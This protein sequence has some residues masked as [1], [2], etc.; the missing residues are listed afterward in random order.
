MRVLVTNDDGIAS[1]GLWVLA[2]T[3]AAEGH[4][5]VVVA[6]QGECSGVGAAI[7]H[8]F[9]GREI[10]VHRAEP[11]C[12]FSGE[13]WALDATPALCT[14]VAQCTRAF[15]P[16]FAACAAGVNP[17]FNTGALV[18]HSGTVGAA[19]TAANTGIP[20]VAVSIGA[21]QS[22]PTRAA[23]DQVAEVHHEGSCH[24]GTAARLAAAALA[25]HAARTEAERPGVVVN[26]NVPNAAPA[27]VLGVREAPLA[28]FPPSFGY[29]PPLEPGATSIRLGLGP[30]GRSL[31]RAR[32]G[33]ATAERV[34]VAAATDTALVAQG[35]ATAT[36]LRPVGAGE[37][38]DVAQVLDD[39]LSAL[40][41]PAGVEANL[42][43]GS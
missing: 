40:R 4:E 41:L 35:W 22:D 37:P 18:L 10:A 5:V 1:D 28:P 14:I 36:T 34:V 24:W 42:A 3:L 19:L 39:A 23:G 27:D 25:W 8:L 17:G 32:A 38:L 13:A 30:P 43:A 15:G 9:M 20:A 2:A 31:G 6:P 16:P 7:G 26:L 29:L 12:G 33:G 21:A 11:R